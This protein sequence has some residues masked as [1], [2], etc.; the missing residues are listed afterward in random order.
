M[1][2]CDRIQHDFKILKQQHQVVSKKVL[3]LILEHQSACN[4]EFLKICEINEK[5][6]ETL[7]LCLNGRKELNVAEKQFSSSLS[8]LANYRK[9]KLMQ[10]LLRNL[11][12]IKTLVGLV[13]VSVVKQLYDCFDFSIVPI[14][15][16]KS[17]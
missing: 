14:I 16:C 7:V 9:R 2:D 10:N 4:G 17:C 13:L 6:K 1:L 5:L 8:I 3:Q 11:K 15:G 12:T